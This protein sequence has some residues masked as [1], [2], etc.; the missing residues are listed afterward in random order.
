MFFKVPEVD[1]KYKNT[2]GNADPVVTVVLSYHGN[3]SGVPLPLAD[4][5]FSDGAHIA[6]KEKTASVKTVGNKIV[7]TSKKNNALKT[8]GNGV[9]EPEKTEAT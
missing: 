2:N 8:T 5:L 3:L 4:K 7:D 6:L 9:A 1:A